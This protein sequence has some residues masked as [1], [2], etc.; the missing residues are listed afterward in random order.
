MN[1]TISQQTTHEPERDGKPLTV[2]IVTLAII[3]LILALLCHV[4]PGGRGRGR[5]AGD[6]TGDGI[7]DTG[8]E[9]EGAAFV[10]TGATDDGTPKTDPEP[11]QTKPTIDKPPA[12][13]P[14]ESPKGDSEKPPE[15][16]VPPAEKMTIGTDEQWGDEAG[17]P[18]VGQGDR[19]GGGGS[20]GTGD[21]S[22][23]MHWKP[24]RGDLDLHV[25]D[26]K[27]HRISHEKRTC[28]CGGKMDRDDTTS[29][30]PE[31]VFWPKGR[32][33]KGEYK[34]HVEYYAGTGDK[35]LVVEVRVKGRVVKTQ[36]DTL[37]KKG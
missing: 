20:L 4:A 9:G 32:A 29:G 31:N 28:A 25:M 36:T 16:K 18:G 33:P 34:F 2:A 14:T 19:A 11:T 15:Q 22:F 6:G 12:E 1:E 37:K 5:G 27:G 35:Q 24:A 7:S 10:E 17:Q 30:G 13:K 23:R 3:A 8:V 26:P 21:L